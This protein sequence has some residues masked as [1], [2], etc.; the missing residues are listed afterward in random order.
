MKKRTVIT[1]L[2]ALALMTG[3]WA[4]AFGQKTKK[5]K[6]KRFEP[7][8]HQNLKDYEGTYIGIEPDYVIEIQVTAD[9]R[10]KVTSL[11]D[12]RSVTVTNIKVTGAR[13]TADKIYANGQR[14]KLNATFSNRILNGESAFGLLVDGL[15]VHLDGGVMLNRVF[16]RRN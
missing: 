15:N 9:G 1:L 5:V 11:E 14:G 8:V 2:L 12:G 16:Y 13:L 7:V 4:E 3:I 6:D 10:L